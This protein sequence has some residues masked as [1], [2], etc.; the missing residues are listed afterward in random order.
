[1][2]A[3][4]GTGIAALFASVPQRYIPQ[5]LASVP[6]ATV[7]MSTLEWALALALL[8]AFAGSVMPILLLRRLDVAAAIT[9][10]VR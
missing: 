7:S 6:H 8:I 3:V 10:R 4:V 1:V 5:F 2:G 9:G